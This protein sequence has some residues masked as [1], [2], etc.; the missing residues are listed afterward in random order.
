MSLDIIVSYHHVQY[1][2]KLMI[3]SLEHLVMGRWTYGRTDSHLMDRHLSIRNIF[4]KSK[5]VFFL[6]K[7]KLVQLSIVIFCVSLFWMLYISWEASYEI[8]LVNLSVRL[9]RFDFLKKVQ[10]CP[11]KIYSFS[12][13]VYILQNDKRKKRQ[14]LQRI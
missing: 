7:S 11:C 6:R 2:R 10:P 14:K 8:T 1:Q 4:G 3:Q 13:I 9:D 5:T 12:S